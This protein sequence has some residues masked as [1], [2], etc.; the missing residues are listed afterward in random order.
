[1]NVAQFTINKRFKLSLSDLGETNG[2]EAMLIDNEPK[3][4]F[5]QFTEL[6]DG[7]TI[8]R[9]WNIDQLSTVIK[10]AKRKA[11]AIIKKEV[12]KS[13]EDLFIK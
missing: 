2:F 7:G 13:N 1:M 8:W 6:N 11:N 9:V 4:E 12:L 5:E 3:E 10:Q